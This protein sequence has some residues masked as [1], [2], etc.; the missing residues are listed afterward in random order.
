[1]DGLSMCVPDTDIP[2]KVMNW[3]TGKVELF[4]A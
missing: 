2:A 3:E 4:A 1:M